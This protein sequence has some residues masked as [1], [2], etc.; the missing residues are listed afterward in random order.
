[1]CLAIF[2]PAGKP[3]PRE[4]LVNGWDNNPDGAGLM[5]FDENWQLQT[6][7]SMTFDK[8]I[9]KYDELW[10]KYGENSPFAIHFRW[11]THGSKT[12]DNVHPFQVSDSCMMMHNGVI[13]CHIPDKKM[14]DTASFAK[15]YLAAMPERWFDNS[16]LFDMVQDYCAG[17]KLIVMT[18]DR[19][20][21][22]CAYIVN[23]HDGF[24]DDE[25]WYSN[26]GYCSARQRAFYTPKS[27][28][29]YMDED[30]VEK[31][32]PLARCELCSEHA[33][34][35]GICYECESCQSC[36]ETEHFCVCNGA[37]LSL[38]SMTDHEYIRYDSVV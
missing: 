18:S 1:M 3:I 37:Q 29:V 10:A 8:F 9:D 27:K 17:S 4:H 19:N 34:F 38:H 24:W 21:E 7:K 31:D 35:D 5:Y 32:M 6:F 28:S 20:A 15:H 36:F 22:Y 33:V 12:I 26:K 30:D 2:Q 11:A 25:I 23:E 16:Y 13:N 14:S